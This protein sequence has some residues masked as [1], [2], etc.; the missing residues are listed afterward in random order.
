MPPPDTPRHVLSLFDIDGTLIRAGDPDH[1]AAFDHA[2]GTVYGVPATL[3]GVPLGGMLDRQIARLALEHHDLD[4]G[5]TEARLG[6]LVEA[7]A[8]H[9]EAAVARGDRL[10]HLLP[11]VTE[12]ATA[13]AAAGVG[14]GVVTGTAA[15]VARAKLH[16][17]H[18]DELLPVGAY[19][20]EADE[21]AD[22]VALAIDRAVGHY[23]R[24]FEPA[25]TVVIGDTPLDVAAAHRA[26]ACALGVATGKVPAQVLAEAGAEV[27]LDD[28]GDPA[29]VVTAVADALRSA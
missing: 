12:A 23:G 7:M 6:A 13:L 29:A 17:A 26:G 3:D 24:P 5:V 8:D 2:L 28:L 25:T 9:Y 16:A 19:G 14:L 27:V 18:L 20:D 22:L 4:P 21:R 1:R 15:R 10:E 11:G